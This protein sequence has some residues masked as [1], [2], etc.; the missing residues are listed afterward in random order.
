MQSLV[1]PELLLKPFAENGDK[2]S[3]PLENQTI[4]QPQLADLTSGFPPITSLDPADGGLPPERKDFNALGFLTTSYDFFYQAG[5]TFTFS[6]TI[7]N[8]IGGYPLGARLWYTDANGV[9]MIV[10]S[11]IENNTNNFISN[12]S[13][14]GET[15]AGTPW[16][17][18]NFRGIK[19]QY[20]LFDFKWQDYELTDINWLRSDT[21]S[22]NDG[23]VYSSAYNHLVNDISGKTSTTE[24]ISGIT[25]TYYL[26]DDGH[27]IVMA[28]QET[29][30]QNIYSET[31]VAWY[32][33]LDTTNQRFKLPRTKYGFVGSRDTVGKYVQESLPNLKGYV[34][35][36]IVVVD[37][38][39]VFSVKQR[40]AKQTSDYNSAT[41]GFTMDAS[42]YSSTYQDNAPVQQRATQMYLY[43]YVGQFSQSA[44]EQTAGLNASLFN[45]KVD[46]NLNNMNP[47]VTAKQTIVGWGL[48]DYSS[49][50][51]VTPPYTATQKGWIRFTA[52]AS[53][54][55]NLNGYGRGYINGVQIVNTYV[56]RWS[57]GT[58]DSAVTPVDV[59][60][61]ATVDIL[62][63]SCEVYFMPCKG[64]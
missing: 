34:D 19:T 49:V 45:G 57:Y 9:S 37:A 59:G 60:D 6:S 26:A 2:N 56:T 50:I 15:G 13:F 1:Q 51:Q 14:I 35:A 31:G 18:E 41:A 46:L 30:V 3:I 24:T 12:P 43:F 7:S 16:E 29:T 27:K 58:Y 52:H 55:D 61:I 23:M 48:P 21:F 63:G 5:G 47:S 28:D 39:G 11:T 54:G 33:I 40:A 8:A 10:R 17:I 36:Q 53:G 62:R 44:T 64:I 42:Q 22:W 38:S 20:D 32:Y 25:V 4:A